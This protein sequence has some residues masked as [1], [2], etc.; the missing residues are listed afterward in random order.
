MLKVE[1]VSTRVY[2]CAQSWLRIRECAQSW[3]NMCKSAKS[4]ESAKV[5]KV[6][7]SK[8]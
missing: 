2:K 7:E 5:E 1:K 8:K 3:E 4:W 6:W